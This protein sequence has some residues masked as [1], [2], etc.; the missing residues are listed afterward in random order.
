MALYQMK[1]KLISHFKVD[2]H[3]H[4][5]TGMRFASFNKWPGGNANQTP[6]KMDGVK[7]LNEYI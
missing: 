2:V 1:E 7:E 3:N 4:C 5:S 6:K